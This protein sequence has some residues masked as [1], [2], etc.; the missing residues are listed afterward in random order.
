VRVFGLSSQ[1]I[2]YQAELVSRLKLPFALLSD[3][4][5]AFANALGLPTFEVA[6]QRLFRRLTLLVTDG[7]VSYVWY[8]VFPPDGHADE[9]LRFLRAQV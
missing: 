4:S 9:V 2:A 5:L 7:D 6:G 1:D 8:P 3:E